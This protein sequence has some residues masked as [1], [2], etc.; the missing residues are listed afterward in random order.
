MIQIR[1]TTCP[2]RHTSAA[3]VWLCGRIAARRSFEYDGPEYDQDHADSVAEARYEA[4][5]YGR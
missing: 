3:A 4:G 5:V 1:C 2:N